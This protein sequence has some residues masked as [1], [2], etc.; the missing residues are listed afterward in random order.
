MECVVGEK[1]TCLQV[2]D[3]LICQS[4]SF[5]HNVLELISFQKHHTTLLKSVCESLE[6]TRQLTIYSKSQ[7]NPKPIGENIWWQ[8]FM[9]RLN[10]Q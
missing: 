7:R 9:A 10:V 5:Q 4:S 8:K 2:Y 3:L 6:A 1:C